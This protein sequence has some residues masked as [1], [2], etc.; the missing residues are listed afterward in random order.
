MGSGVVAQV[1]METVV[2]LLVLL[3]SLVLLLLL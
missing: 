1:S 2:S 3:L